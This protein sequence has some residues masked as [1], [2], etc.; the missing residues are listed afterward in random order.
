M[1]RIDVSSTAV[2]GVISLY[3][4][5]PFSN[6]FEANTP[7]DTL[8]FTGSSVELISFLSNPASNQVTFSS[9]TGFNRGYTTPLSL[10]IE[11]LCGTTVMQTLSNSVT[12]GTGRFFP[13][14]QGSVYSFFRNEPI[15]PQ[16]FIASIPV[17]NPITTPTLPAG[18]SLVRTGSNSFDLSGVPA[19]QLVASNYKVIGKGSVDPTR[20]VTVDV[21]IRVGAERLLMDVCGSTSVPLSVG[22]PKIGRAHV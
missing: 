10:V 6:F 8:R 5:E 9:T 4:Y 3:A 18:L 20:I 14:A 22:T 1:S 2:G 19:V 21:N 7:P 17:Q 12:V 13:P 16:P 11:D 15:V